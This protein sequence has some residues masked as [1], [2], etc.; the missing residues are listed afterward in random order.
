MKYYER[1]IKSGS[2]LEVIRYAS[3]REPGVNFP[4]GQNQCKSST[5][6]IL[7]NLVNAKKNLVRLI[8]AN[9]GPGDLL[10]VLTYE[11]KPPSPNKAKKDLKKYVRRL[12]EY[13]KKTGI[14]LCW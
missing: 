8:N 4:R 13:G 5:A 1:R 10:L 9:F 14:R 3:L 7:R 12:R 11:G 6:Q 2:I